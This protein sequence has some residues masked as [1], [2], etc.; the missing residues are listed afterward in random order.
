MKNISQSYLLVLFCEHN[1]QNFLIKI[2][3]KIFSL[4]SRKFTYNFSYFN[5]QMCI[6]ICLRPYLKTVASK[7]VCKACFNTSWQAS[8]SLFAAQLTAGTPGRPAKYKPDKEWTTARNQLW[9]ELED[10][11][12]IVENVAIHR[13][14]PR[15]AGA[16]TEKKKTC[17]GLGKHGVYAIA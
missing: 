2:P 4:T 10:G 6:P 11:Y 8:Q 5:M 12:L 13:P 16:R 9:R 17:A 1:M 3:K 7:L 14:P 15:S